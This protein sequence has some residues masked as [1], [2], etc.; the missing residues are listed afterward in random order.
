MHEG[1]KQLTTNFVSFLKLVAVPKS[2]LP[3]WP[4]GAGRIIVAMIKKMHNFFFK[5]VFPS[6]GCLTSLLLATL[7]V[8]CHNRH[9]MQRL[10]EFHFFFL[11]KNKIKTS[12][13]TLSASQ[14]LIICMFNV[15]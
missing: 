7:F 11:V 4:T 13:Y 12:P 8:I 10:K 15:K 3:V 5:D 9:N 1:Q 6:H 14:L 2:N